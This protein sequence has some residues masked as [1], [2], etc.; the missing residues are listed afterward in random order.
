[1]QT[2]L[3]FEVMEASWEEFCRDLKTV[4]DLDSLVAAHDAY[5]GSI[6]RKALLGDGTLGDGGA[7]GRSNVQRELQGGLRSI[8]DLA[9]PVKRLN[10]MVGEGLWGGVCVVV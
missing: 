6:L 7:D 5:V 3:H 1:M 8:L 10:E 4:Q 9:G 2:Y